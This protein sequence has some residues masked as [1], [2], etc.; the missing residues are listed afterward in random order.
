MTHDPLE[1]LVRGEVV[2]IDVLGSSMWPLL[3]AGDRLTVAPWEGPPRVGCVAVAVI[4]RALV[5]HRVIEV[6]PEHVR[7]QGDAAPLP[8]AP[9][10]PVAVLGRVVAARSPQGRHRPLY[11]TPDAW[12]RW[13]P[14]ARSLARSRRALAAV[15]RAVVPGRA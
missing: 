15:V 3:R 7:M 2:Q 14:V 10:R 13:M 8:D 6:L 12:Q 9:L 4:G 5:A 1:G 11:D